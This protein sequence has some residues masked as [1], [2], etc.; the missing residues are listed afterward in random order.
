VTSSLLLHAEMHAAVFLPPR[1]APRS[2]VLNR[3]GH[4]SHF[5]DTPIFPV[6]LIICL[7]VI[8][9]FIHVTHVFKS[10]FIK[11]KRVVSVHAVKACRGSRSIAPHIRNLRKEC[12]WAP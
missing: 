1:Y 8:V 10:N 7:T 12:K 4:D 6:I 2:S 5:T 9:K 3:H 11:E